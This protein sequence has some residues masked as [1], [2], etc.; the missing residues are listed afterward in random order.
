MNKA[1]HTV[2]CELEFLSEYMIVK[3]DL[4]YLIFSERRAKLSSQ[5]ISNIMVVKSM[6][7]SVSEFDP[8]EAISNWLVNISK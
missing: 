4:K 6:T 5:A 3:I 1:L 2:I 8:Q 7:P